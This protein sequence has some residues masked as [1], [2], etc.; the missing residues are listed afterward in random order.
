MLQVTF[1]ISIMM[2]YVYYFL[3]WIAARPSE[4]GIVSMD[5][6]TQ[7][8]DKGLGNNADHCE[9]PSSYGEATTFRKVSV[10]S[11]TKN[12]N[13]RESEQPTTTSSP[14]KKV[15]IVQLQ[16]ASK[17]SSAI[18]KKAVSHDDLVTKFQTRFYDEG[19][20]NIQNT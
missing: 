12:E 11:P 17:G 16:A 7:D 19:S 4:K 15:S 1:L 5:T 8:I 2:Q 14:V 3:S 18:P 10:G 20:H 9:F 13:V 6:L